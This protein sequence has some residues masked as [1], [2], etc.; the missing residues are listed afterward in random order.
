M[1]QMPL[2]IE[3]VDKKIFHIIRVYHLA[4]TARVMI[5]KKTWGLEFRCGIP[6]EFISCYI[7]TGL[8][9][10]TDLGLLFGPPVPAVDPFHI[11][12]IF[13]VRI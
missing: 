11:P 5:Q 12:E 7:P 9:Q 10:I 3:V 4:D 1:G 13:F 6:F 2:W 8:F